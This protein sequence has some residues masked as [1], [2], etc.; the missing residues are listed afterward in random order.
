MLSRRL[1]IPLAFLK[2]GKDGGNLTALPLPIFK[3]AEPEVNM[4]LNATSLFGLPSTHNPRRKQKNLAHILWYRKTQIASIRIIFA[5]EVNKIFH[6]EKL[7][8]T[9]YFPWSCTYL[10]LPPH[11]LTRPLLFCF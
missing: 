11:T 7:R 9:I 4:Q 2:S 1:I 5:Y 8:K 10:L 3:I 6:S